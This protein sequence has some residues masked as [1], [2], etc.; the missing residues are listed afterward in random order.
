MRSTSQLSI[1]LPKSL[2]SLVKARVASGH[3]ASESEVIRDGLR[4]LLDRERA[5]DAWL[6]RDVVPT[7]E[8]LRADRSRALSGDEVRRQL[9]SGRKKPAV[10][11]G[12]ST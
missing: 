2:A 11:R 12:R 6:Q 8:A 3:Y 9:G 5:I 7:M 4:A 10:K 1:T